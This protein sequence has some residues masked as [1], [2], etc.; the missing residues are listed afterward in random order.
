MHFPADAMA[1]VFTN[2]RIAI[3]LGMACDRP[4]DLSEPRTWANRLDAHPHS[5]IGGLDQPLGEW[6]YLTDEVSF[7]GICNIAVLLK[8]NVEVDDVA[9][10]KH[11][12]LRW[13]AVTDH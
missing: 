12:R 9:V 7:A 10:S 2:H 4:T 11:V 3:S 5:F 1:A 6:V 8:S 13:N